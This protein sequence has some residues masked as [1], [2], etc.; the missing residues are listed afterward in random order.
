MKKIVIT[1]AN[2]FIGSHLVRH[3]AEKGF[4]IIAL[5]RKSP[6]FIHPN[7]IHFPWELGIPIDENIWK[8]VQVLIH[9]AWQLKNP[10]KET[11]TLNYTG[12]NLIA[13]AALKYE[14][15][16]I[17]ISS[18]S[19]HE[20]AI[21]HYGS[22]KWSAEKLFTDKNDLI[23]RPGLVAGNGGIAKKISE[24]ASKKKFMLVPSNGYT[25]E[26][27]SITQLCQA[28]EQAIISNH[29]GVFNLVTN[30]TYTFCNLYRQLS[31][32]KG[33]K[34]LVIAI[35]VNWI[36]PIAIIVNRIGLLSALTLESIKGMKKPPSPLNELALISQNQLQGEIT[37]WFL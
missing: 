33:R 17:F 3:L 14:I 9:A 25:V 27:I 19:A 28:I 12:T 13:Q 18:R 30:N 15:K 6:D 1:G 26:L 8:D 4:Q 29:T 24:M 5:S 7:V 37:D 10:G 35:P 16:R 11:D 36:Y 31:H 34:A 22:T 20:N 32:K 21:S 23:I 2:G